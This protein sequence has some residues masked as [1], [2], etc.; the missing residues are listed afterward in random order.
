[1]QP[2]LELSVILTTYQ[3]PEHL[4]RSLASLALQGG[5]AG[6][7]EVIVTDDGSQDHT[8]DIVREFARTADFPVKLITHPHDG[9]RVALCR[10]DGV[11]ASSAPYFLFS[12]SDCI[13]PP[14]HVRGHLKARRP[15]VIRAGHCYRLDREATER[16]DVAAVVANAYRK[17][18]APVERRRMMRRWI[19]DKYYQWTRH[20][21]RPKL[22]GCNIAIW[23]RD[24]EAV[25][26]FDEDFVGWGCEDDDL[27]IRLRA[28]GRRIVSVIGYTR[29][30]HMWH[31]LDPS[32]PGVWNQGANVSRLVLGDKP[33]RCKRGL[34]GL[35]DAGPG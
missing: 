6:R 26:G 5:V 9:F 3:R 28:I 16:L 2:E 31:P 14:N 22:T 30:Y 18:V 4:E 8:Q 25:N 35:A 7:F 19:S 1:M 24:L 27:A 11:R 10:N 34:G 23:R 33:A 20:A 13:F 17:C 32:H 29:A 21:A 12:D 15:G